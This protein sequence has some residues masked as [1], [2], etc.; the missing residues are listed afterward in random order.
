MNTIKIEKKQVRMVAHRGLSGLEKENTCAAFIAAGNRSHFGIETDIRPT[1]DG[2]YVCMHDNHTA[3]VSVDDL[4]IDRCT[5][6]TLRSL[7]L[8]GKDGSKQRVD[9]HIPTL[10]EY[11][12]ICRRYEKTSVLELKDTLTAAD[13]E[14]II[15]IARNFGW[16]EH[17]IFISFSLEAMQTVRRLLP[18]Q[19]CQYLVEQYTDDLP[20]LLQREKLDLDIGYP[21]LTAQRVQELH[22][23]GIVVNC[24]T[25]DDPAAAAAL[26]E[27]GLDYITSN[28]LE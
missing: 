27:M 24:W 12:D 22:A 21:A 6:D 8:T 13:I 7:I 19:P 28:I 3:R 2:R 15:G 26:V 11:L 9:L 10:E 20:E 1:L 5:F 23:R 16:L 18:D 17:V 14:K 25:C 4:Q